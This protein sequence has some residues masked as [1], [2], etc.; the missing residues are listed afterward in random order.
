MGNLQSQNVSA[1]QVIAMVSL[2]VSLCIA[3]EG[4]MLERSVLGCGAGSDPTGRCLPPSDAG[5][6]AYVMMTDGDIRDA[7]RDAPDAWVDIDGDLPVDAGPDAWVDPDGGPPDSGPPDGG[8]PDS[9][10]V[11]AGPPPPL[12][13]T[14]NAATGP[15]GIFIR[16]AWNGPG[17]PEMADYYR[18]CLISG[19]GSTVICDADMPELLGGRIIRFFP[20]NDTLGAAVCSP[21][22][23]ASL[24]TRAT[25]PGSPL[26]GMYA[27]DISYNTTPVLEAAV[28]LNPDPGSALDGPMPG[29]SAWLEFR[30][31]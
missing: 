14:F 25:C 28:T 27:Y 2:S 15:T 6:D 29:D 26:S 11:D 12:R 3:C 22:T 7:G 19:S 10:P 21:A 8:P 13:I 30:L 4:C 24:C 20:F 23:C 1:M 9:G 31:P 17:G 18:A 16:V 5:V